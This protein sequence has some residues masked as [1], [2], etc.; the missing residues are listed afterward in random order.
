MAAAAPLVL[1]TPINSTSM[2]R[3]EAQAREAFVVAKRSVSLLVMRS[4]SSALAK[5]RR[6]PSSLPTASGWLAWATHAN[7][8]FFMRVRTARGSVQPPCKSPRTQGWRLISAPAAALSQRRAKT[9]YSRFMMSV[10]L[11]DSL[12]ACSAARPPVA[13]GSLQAARTCWYAQSMRHG[14]TWCAHEAIAPSRRC[15]LR[16]ICRAPHSRRMGCAFL[17]AWRTAA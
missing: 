14:P 13:S 12:P 5:L 4:V 2:V 6:P 9:D 10:P 7:H 17:S 16:E 3:A 1:P 15:T 11:D 8:S